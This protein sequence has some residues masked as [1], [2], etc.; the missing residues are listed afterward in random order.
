MESYDHGYYDGGVHLG[1]VQDAPP[2]SKE[3]HMIGTAAAG[4]IGAGIVSAGNIASTAMTNH[5]NRKMTEATNKANVDLWHKQNEYNHPVNQIARL[6][7]AGLNP[8]LIYH[9]ATGASGIAGTPPQ[10]KSPKYHAPKINMDFHAYARARHQHALAENAIRENK[11]IGYQ[12]EYIKSQTS[13]TDAQNMLTAEK[14][15]LIQSQMSLITSQVAELNHNLKATPSYMSTK[16]HSKYAFGG[17]TLHGVWQGAKKVGHWI[18][19]E[20]HR[21]RNNI[22]SKYK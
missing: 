1:L 11:N 3:K 15:N 20:F 10:L 4:L 6:K 17:R 21:E 5:H 7:K 9:S 18:K 2:P 14:V 19:N 13:F 12:G 16:D 22:R 8:N